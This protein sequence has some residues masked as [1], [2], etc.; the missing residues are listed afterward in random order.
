MGRTKKIRRVEE[1][2]KVN[3]NYCKKYRQKIRKPIEC[4]KLARKSLKYL[5]PKKYKLQ[6]AK[7]RARS[8]RNRERK[9]TKQLT[10]QSMERKRRQ[11]LQNLKNQNKT[12]FR[13]DRY[14]NEVSKELKNS[15]RSVHEND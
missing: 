4:K 14:T 11:Q 8:Q 5:E 7:D 3:I 9:E 6:L 1:R 12:L 15:S 13:Q 2:K 10:Q